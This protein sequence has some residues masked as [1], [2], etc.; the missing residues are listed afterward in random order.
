MAV[1]GQRM[2]RMEKSPDDTLFAYQRYPVDYWFKHPDIHGLGLFMEPGTGK[3]KPFSLIAKKC[4]ADFVVYFSPGS[5]RTVFLKELRRQGENIKRVAYNKVERYHHI[6]SNAGNIYDQWHNFLAKIGTDISELM[7]VDKKPSR[8]KRGNEMQDLF[9]APSAK[10]RIVPKILIIIDEAHKLS[11]RIANVL[12]RVYYEKSQSIDKDPEEKGVYKL[13][14]ELRSITHTKFIMA[15]GTPVPNDSFDAVPML[16]ILRGRIQTTSGQYGFAFPDVYTNFYFTF[17]HPRSGEK[18]HELFNSRIQNLIYWYRIPR[19]IPHIPVPDISA[20]HTIQLPMEQYQW[21]RYSRLASKEEE[22]EKKT[23]SIRPQEGTPF[24]SAMGIF[25]TFTRQASNYIYPD[26][27]A[28]FEDKL[29]RLKPE[30]LDLKVVKKHSIKMWSILTAVLKHEDMMHGIYSHFVNEYGIAVMERILVNLGWKSLEHDI[31]ASIDELEKV[32]LEE[33][34]VTGKIQYRYMPLTG[35]QT[36]ENKDRM[37]HIVNTQ[38]NT[39]NR[40]V[41]VIFFSGAAGLGLSVYG[42]RQVHLLEPNWNTGD[43]EQAIDRFARLN[44]A[45]YLPLNKRNIEVFRYL[46]LPPDK[47]DKVTTDVH[48]YNVARVKEERNLTVKSMIASASIACHEIFEAE[49]KFHASLI[50]NKVTPP[51]R[52]HVEC[53]SC[54]SELVPSLILQ[55]GIGLS[56]K[57]TVSKPPSGKNA[58]KIKEDGGKIYTLDKSNGLGWVDKELLLDTRLLRELW[59][60]AKKK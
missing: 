56:C 3:T 9:D 59:K 15:T 7:P 39:E 4:D 41:R 28:G 14:L 25:K 10:S 60:I 18:K 13:Y 57:P 26:D 40:Y 50:K 30:H 33:K 23:K 35:K 5:L 11:Q 22:L 58:I 24:V 29:T 1:I 32:M 6:S 2:I 12:N 36:V 52:N 20:E 55:S 48:I 54:Q 8:E 53:L 51:M 46:A 16:N 38:K 27:I 19:G 45:Q 47:T 44:S 37:L 43:E 49:N 31:V 42:V 34:K 17:V 21:I